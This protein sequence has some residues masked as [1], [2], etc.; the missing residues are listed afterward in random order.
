MFSYNL[1][2]VLRYSPQ[3]VINLYLQPTSYCPLP[4]LHIALSHLLP[5]LFP[6]YHATYK[7]FYCIPSLQLLHKFSDVIWHV[8]WSITGNILA[9][10]G[11][12]NKVSLWKETLEGQWVCISDMKDK[13]KDQRTAA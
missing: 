6:S 7:T 5:I 10:S 11:G 13:D 12:A 4:T 1:L 9:V 8:S 2:L 3:F